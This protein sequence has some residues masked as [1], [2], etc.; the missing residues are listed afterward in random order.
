MLDLRGH[1]VGAVVD[2]VCDV[3]ELAGDDAR[4]ADGLQVLDIDRLFAGL[5]L[6]DAAR[7]A[8]GG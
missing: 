2:S 8:A 6:F 5:D 7:P 4:G 1:T 3:F